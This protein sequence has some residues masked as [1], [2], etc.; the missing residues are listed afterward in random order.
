MVRNVHERTFPVGPEAVGGLIDDLA[1]PAERLWPADSWPAMRFDRPLGVGAR[2]GHG[3][4][5]YR[6]E[7]YEPGATI[8]FRFEAPAG[9]DGFHGYEVLDAGHGATTLREVLECR[10]HGAARLTWPLVFGPLHDALIED[11]LTRA[12]SSLGVSPNP[13]MRWSWWVRALRRLAARGPTRAW[14]GARFPTERLW[15][16]SRAAAA[17]RNGC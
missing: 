8:R 11:S 17:R 9:F 10:L 6:V 16:A 12:G 15:R 2:G 14:S 1:S 4:I 3:P 13:A 7:K 5:R